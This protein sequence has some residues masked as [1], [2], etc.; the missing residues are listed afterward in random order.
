MLTSFNA[1]SRVEFGRNILVLDTGVLL[2]VA[3]DRTLPDGNED[4]SGDGL[5]AEFRQGWWR[6]LR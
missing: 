6:Q 4:G 5:T 1:S 3:M 2:K